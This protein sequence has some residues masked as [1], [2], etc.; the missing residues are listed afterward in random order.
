MLQSFEYNDSKKEVNKASIAGG[1]LPVLRK[2]GG[3]GFTPI[4]GDRVG[5]DGKRTRRFDVRR[6]CPWLLEDPRQSPESR[7]IKTIDADENYYFNESLILTLSEVTRVEYRPL[8]TR[9]I[10]PVAFLNEP[11]ASQWRY[12]QVEGFGEAE[13]TSESSNNPRL[14]DVSGK[15]FVNDIRELRIAVKFTRQELLKAD[16]ARRNSMLGGS[17]L[18]R[19]KFE[20]ARQ[21]LLRSE[22]NIAW[23]GAEDY[24]LQGYLSQ[25]TGIEQEAAAFP[26]SES[27][28]AD[29]ILEVMNNAVTK[30]VQTE[31][32]SPNTLG[33]GTRAFTVVNQKK[34]GDNKDKTVAASFLE[35]NPWIQEIVWIPQLGYREDLFDQLIKDGKTVSEAQRLAGGIE[36]QDVMMTWNRD[37]SRSRLIVAQDF[38]TTTPFLD[39]VNDTYIMNY[40]YTG[41][42]EIKRPRAH[43]L[44]VGV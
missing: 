12:R 42:M 6:D 26:I 18:Q 39:R 21:A 35:D 9:S 16:F 13:I 29:Q 37:P 38:V 15:E 20:A 25:G 28:S 1:F 4:R 7:Y 17:D 32:E 2:D 31:V 19:D 22:E 33:L 3:H 36:G 8:T 41:G 30:V 40:L 44:T 24:N 11:G 14:A 10:V 43:H 34:S 27:S 23:F 5:R